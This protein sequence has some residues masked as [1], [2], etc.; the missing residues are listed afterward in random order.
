MQ[1]NQELSGA[2]C[3]DS[4]RLLALVEVSHR[5]IS[6]QR[7]LD[8]VAAMVFSGH[9]SV[10]SMQL[11]TSLSDAANYCTDEF[12]RLSQ[13]AHMFEQAGLLG[14]TE[15]TAIQ[16]QATL[17]FCA[18]HRI[19]NELLKLQQ[20]AAKKAVRILPYLGPKSAAIH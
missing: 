8:L 2:N 6:M 16:E 4:I 5:I 15:I 17:L 1:L 7:A 14:E 19:H 20:Q 12:A 3:D 9:L 11:A 13:E 18:V 10:D